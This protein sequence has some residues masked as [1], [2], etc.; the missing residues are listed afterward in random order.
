MQILLY[1]PL[2]FSEEAIY[3]QNLSEICFNKYKIK[4]PKW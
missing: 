2:I 4:K 3:I 1:F